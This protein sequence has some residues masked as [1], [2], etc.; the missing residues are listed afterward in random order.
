[1]PFRDEANGNYYAFICHQGK[2]TKQRLEASTL[3]HAKRECDEARR[4]L[5]RVDLKA[6]KITLSGL[7]VDYLK[8]LRQAP[9][10]L[11]GGKP[12]LST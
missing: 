11:D 8:G 5:Q 9:K 2:L 7:C 4:K 12:I 1:M 10:T 6:G 3:P